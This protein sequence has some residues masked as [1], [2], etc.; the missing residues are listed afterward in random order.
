MSRGVGR[1]SD[2]DRKLAG[3]TRWNMTRGCCWFLYRCRWRRWMW[4]W[5]RG[6]EQ[7]RRTGRLT[8]RQACGWL[9]DDS[10]GGGNESRWLC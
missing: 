8:S 3:R 7:C 2:S 1:R 4:C 10:G 5:L 9:D 6:R